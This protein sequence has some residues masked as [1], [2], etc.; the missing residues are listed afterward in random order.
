MLPE[1]KQSLQSV[2]VAAKGGPPTNH[3]DISSLSA[4]WVTPIG[5][6]LHYQLW[7]L[8]CQQNLFTELAFTLDFTVPLE[9]NVWSTLQA[10]QG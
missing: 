4:Q 2:A 3:L 9:L 1:P 6:S 8:K 5:K 10:Q 7:A